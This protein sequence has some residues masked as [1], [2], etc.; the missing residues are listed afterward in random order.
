[1][2]EKK[3]NKLKHKPYS[4]VDFINWEL[5]ASAF[6]ANCSCSEVASKLGMHPET[7]AKAITKK[8]K[9]P[10]V[11]YVMQRRQEGDLLLK[12][13]IFQVAMS[14][15]RTMLKFVGSTRLG[16]VER[17]EVEIV[18]IP[19]ISWSQTLEIQEVKE[20]TQLNELNETVNPNGEAE[21]SGLLP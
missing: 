10:M 7:L 16:M 2:V 4:K 9:V 20:V 12:M 11:E 13:K 15:D 18:N 6:Q 5:V 1:M 19:Q 17:H 3:V 14:G 8:F 21:T